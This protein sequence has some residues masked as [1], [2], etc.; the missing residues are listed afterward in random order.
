MKDLKNNRDVCAYEI[1]TSPVEVVRTTD[2][3]QN[4]IRLLNEH[5]IGAVAVLDSDGKPVGVITK[6][7]IIR[8]A[9]VSEN[10]HSINKKANKILTEEEESLIPTRDQEDI[11][12]N[13]MTPVIFSVKSETPVKEVAKRMVRYGIHHIFVQEKQDGHILGVVSSFDILRYVADDKESKM[14]S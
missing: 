2:S 3:L 5:N 9:E 13:W 12:L 6:T 10:S 1:M 7:D 14:K 11:V 4:V 8:Y